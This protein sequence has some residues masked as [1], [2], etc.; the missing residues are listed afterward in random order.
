MRRRALLEA[1]E[2]KLL[3]LL[4]EIVA[5]EGDLV[6]VENDM[7]DFRD[8]IQAVGSMGGPIWPIVSRIEANL[9]IKQIKTE[10]EIMKKADAVCNYNSSSR[11][12]CGFLSL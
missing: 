7:L 12:T 3:E 2:T 6:T 9:E 1:R 10:E 11:R 4:E 8:D 5:L